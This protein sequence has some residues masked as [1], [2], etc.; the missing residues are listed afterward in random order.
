MPI[1]TIPPSKGFPRVPHIK[2]KRAPPEKL[3]FAYESSS[4]PH[5]L[6]KTVVIEMPA[7]RRCSPIVLRKR[8]AAAFIPVWHALWLCNRPKVL[9]SRHSISRALR[10]LEIPWICTPWATNHPE[11]MVSIHHCSVKCRQSHA[12]WIFGAHTMLLCYDVAS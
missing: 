1:K 9:T 2:R 8:I 11:S 7:D 6:S 10:A 3:T 4:C 5:A 12:S